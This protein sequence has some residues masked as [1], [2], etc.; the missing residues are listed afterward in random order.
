[1]YLELTDE[2]VEA[3]IRGLR[4]LI[5]GD[6]YPLSPRIAGAA[7]HSGAVAAGASSRAAAAATELRAAEQGEVSAT[8]IDK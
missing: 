3:L 1:M 8:R 6:R 5:D 4:K 7:E 2:Q